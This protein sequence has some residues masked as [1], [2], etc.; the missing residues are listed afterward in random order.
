MD[1]EDDRLELLH[2]GEEIE[3][4]QHDR[5]EE[6]RAE[7]DDAAVEEALDALDEAIEAGENVMDPI[8]D[9]VKLYATMGE[10][11]AVFEDQYGAYQETIGL[12]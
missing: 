7:R 3:D 2:V 11:M 1:E 9:A 10:V 12:A 6:V 8:I 5:L 4:R